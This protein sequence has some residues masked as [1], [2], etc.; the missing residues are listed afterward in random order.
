MVAGDRRE[1]PDGTPPPGPRADPAQATGGTNS[2]PRTGWGRGGVGWGRKK[3]RLPLARNGPSRL[4]RR[5]CALLIVQLPVLVLLC[6]AV[7]PGISWTKPV[8]FFDLALSQASLVAALV[9]ARWVIHQPSSI[10]ATPASQVDRPSIPA[11]YAYNERRKPPQTEVPVLASSTVADVAAHC[12][13]IGP[14]HLY[15]ASVIGQRHRADGGAREDAFAVASLDGWAGAAAVADGVGNTRDA[16]AAST[17]AAQSAAL[18]SANW[19]SADNRD[20]PAFTAR[21]T[22]DVSSRLTSTGDIVAYSSTMGYAGQPH[23]GQHKRATPAT[24]LA[25]AA[26]RPADDGLDVWWMA[27]GDTGL[28]ILADAWT[29]VSPH[30]DGRTRFGTHALPGP[31]AKIRHGSTHLSSG[32]ILVLATDGFMAALHDLADDLGSRIR[33]AVGETRS[34]SVFSTILDFDIPELADDKTVVVI[35]V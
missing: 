11:H 30:E 6:A 28:L 31:A 33:R 5:V 20:W 32:Q 27:Y 34:P 9:L 21:L 17:I 26:F 8:S 22:D 16:H 24:T 10:G 29:A 2:T 23:T 4:A 7:L 3:A 1:S 15:A 19:I 13:R 14:V 18:S 35:A 25:V 12:A